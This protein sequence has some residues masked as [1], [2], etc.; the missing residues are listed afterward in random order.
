MLLGFI[1]KFIEVAKD[2]G[3]R[4]HSTTLLPAPAL[5]IGLLLLPGHPMG[6]QFSHNPAESSVT[7]K[8]FEIDDMQTTDRSMMPDGLL[9]S[10][11]D[12]QIR[13]LVVYLASPEQVPLPLLE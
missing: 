10:F 5:F 1:M 13:D 8:L 7:L 9:Q 2:G 4:G 3:G 6:S 11:T 12:E